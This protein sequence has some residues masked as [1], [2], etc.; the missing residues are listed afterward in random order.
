MRQLKG[1]WV[2]KRTENLLNL[3][4]TGRLE[5]TSV[6]SKELAVTLAIAGIV[7]IGAAAMIDIQVVKVVAHVAILLLGT[8]AAVWKRQKN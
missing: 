2:K 6:W 7:S 8:A 1:E 5:N 4:H 3:L